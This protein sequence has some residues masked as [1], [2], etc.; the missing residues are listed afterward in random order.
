MISIPT[1]PAKLR[2]FG[3][4]NSDDFN[5]VIIH[6]VVQ[7]VWL[8]KTYDDDSKALVISAA[9]SALKAFAP[10]D[11]LEAMIAAQAIAMHNASMECSR[12]AM[13]PEQTSLGTRDCRKAATNASRAFTDLLAALDRKR[14]KGGQQRVTVEHVHVHAGGQAIVGAIEGSRGGGSSSKAK[15]EPHAP[16]TA[17]A[18]DAPIGATSP[19]LRSADAARERV[20]VPGNAER[21]LPD[22]RG[23]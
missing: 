19:P 20:P 4:S 21:P 12:R 3:G 5:N 8:P 10:T 23:I 7:S 16:P 18:D 13:L 9:Y 17:V 22:A 2:A 6:N 14:G 1:E 11:E 15:G